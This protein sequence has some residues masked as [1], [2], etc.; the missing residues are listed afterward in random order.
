MAQNQKLSEI[1]AAG[2]IAMASGLHA[3]QVRAFRNYQAAKLDLEGKAV[4]LTGPNG[5]GKTNLLEAVSMLAPG[6]GLRRAQRGEIGYLHDAPDQFSAPD[7]RPSDGAP[8]DSGYSDSGGND[9]GDVQGTAWSVFAELT[10]P[11]GFAAVGTGRAPDHPETARRVVKVNGMAGAQTDLARLVTLSWLTPQMDGLFIGA[12]SGR[13]RFI[14]RLAIAFDPA[15]SGRLSR[16]EKAWRERSRLLSEGQVDDKW[17]VSLEKILAETGI[18]I[19]A[20][21][22]ALIEDINRESRLLAS[23]F[24]VVNA[25]LTGQAA[26]WLGD[27]LPA[28]DIED[29]ILLAAR[30]NRQTGLASMPGPHETDLALVYKGQSAHLASTGEQKALMIA[31]VLA[32]AVLQDKRLSRPPILLLDDVA[33][34]LDPARRAEL[35]SLC[36]ELTGQVWYSGVDPHAFSA[37]RDEAQFIAVS[38]GQLNQ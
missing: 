23:S 11:E 10:G 22:S 14:D 4:V 32:H 19:S 1:G 6:R 9:A 37:L 38:H 30:Q 18:A 13:R 3:L 26:D 31:M 7:S 2:D 27:G 17:C 21:R 36:S 35:F 20:T 15:H 34:H 16:Y 29:R 33:A 24:P 25:R 12:P 5:A 8:F 28:I